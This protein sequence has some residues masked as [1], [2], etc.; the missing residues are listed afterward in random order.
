MNKDVKGELSGEFLKING[1]PDGRCHFIANC[2]SFVLLCY[3]KDGH[4]MR[5]PQLKYFPKEGRIEI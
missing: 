4:K 1:A 2:K 5:G 3:F